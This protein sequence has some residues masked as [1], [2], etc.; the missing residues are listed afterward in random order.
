MYKMPRVLS[1]Y[2]YNGYR[3]WFKVD[4]LLKILLCI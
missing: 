2:K 1:S 4:L 3:F